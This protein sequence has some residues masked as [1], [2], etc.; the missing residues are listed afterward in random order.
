MMSHRTSRALKTTN[1]IIAGALAI[2]LA[3]G[4]LAA[5]EAQQPAATSSEPGMALLLEV[6]GAIGP[7]T[8]EYIAK[9]LQQAADTGARLVILEMDTPGGLDSATA[10]QTAF[11]PSS[12]GWEWP[13]NEAATAL[14]ISCPE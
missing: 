10:A 9:G 13:S 12:C 1:R 11:S 3:C 14:R 8:S 7:A 2:G 5:Q 4:I 6:R